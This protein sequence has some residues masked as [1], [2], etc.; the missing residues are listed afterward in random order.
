MG[1]E[2]NTDRFTSHSFK[3]RIDKMVVEENG[4]IYCI[5]KVCSP[6]WIMSKDESDAQENRVYFENIPNKI[7]EAEKL[8]GY[9]A[10]FTDEE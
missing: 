3:A 2:G 10:I 9:N 6:S 1:K 5:K 8:V 7:R 4:S